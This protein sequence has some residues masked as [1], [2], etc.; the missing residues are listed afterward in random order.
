MGS[1]IVDEQSD[2][3][4]LT[5]GYMKKQHQKKVLP[6]ETDY[7]FNKSDVVV[8]TH[9]QG[10]QVRV[11]ADSNSVD[12]KGAKEEDSQW[13]AEPSE[14]GKSVTF[15]S[16]KTGKYLRINEQKKFDV[17]GEGGKLCI[18]KVKSM[19]GFIK[20]ES[21]EFKGHCL[22]CIPGKTVMVGGGGK[23]SDMKVCIK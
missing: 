2:F 12:G 22:G 13:I 4:V 18:F 3:L 5:M 14:G 16:C 8:I 21:A 6:F 23:Y 11:L 10:G 20:L 17:A 9:G 19:N 15:K 7:E 1:E